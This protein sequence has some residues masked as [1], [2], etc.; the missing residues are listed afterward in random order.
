MKNEGVERHGEGEWY[1]PHDIQFIHKTRIVFL[2]H[3]VEKIG[4]VSTALISLLD[5]LASDEKL[6][7]S[8]ILFN[9]ADANERLPRAI[10]LLKPPLLL[11]SYF[12]DRRGLRGLKKCLWYA[13][14]IVGRLISQRTLLRCLLILS[15]KERQQFDYAIAFENNIPANKVDLCG[16]GYVADK[17]EAEKKIAY[18]HNDPY[19][20]G[21]TR[22][23]VLKTYAPFDVVVCVSKGCMRKLMDICPEFKD[24]YKIAHNCLSYNSSFPSKEPRE[25]D[26]FRLVSI[27][28]LDNKQKRIDRA[29]ECCAILLDRGYHFTWDIYGAGQDESWLRELAK[30][31]G[32]ESVLSFRGV[33]QAPVDVIHD[34]DLF[35]MTSDYEALGMTLIEARVAKTPVVTTDFEEAKESVIN[36]VTGWIVPRDSLQIANKI[37]EIISDPVLL[38]AIERRIDAVPFS[39][40]PCVEEFYRAVLDSGLE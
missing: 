31:S 22:E 35:V 29:I 1:M 9:Q 16:I 21:F 30:A 11:S 10:T 25:I 19:K 5:E 34:Y 2:A 7:V 20:L 24:K 39:N 23:Y 14:H 36:G 3:G 38:F 18:I 33:T 26:C 27:S 15:P 40:A 32:V 6:D 17:I 8:A 4:G 13:L 28:R 12:S 37:S